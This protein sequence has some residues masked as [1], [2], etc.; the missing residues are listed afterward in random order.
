VTDPV[1]RAYAQLGLSPGASP[2]LLR[3]QYKALVRRWHPDR[4]AGDPQGQNEASLRL[5]A[6]NEAYR[7]L[8]QRAAPDTGP[9]PPRAS[10]ARGQSL[11]REEIDR[12]VQALG[13]EGPVDQLLAAL[14]VLGRAVWIPFA[15]VSAALLVLRVLFALAGADWSALKAGPGF[16]LLPVLVSVVLTAWYFQLKSQG[17]RG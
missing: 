5:R 6:I 16:F 1:S 17:G 10:R 9:P 15:V 3:K 7:L 11:S 12:I 2:E 4:F 14:G 13:T 8:V